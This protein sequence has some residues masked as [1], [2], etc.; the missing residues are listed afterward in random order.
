MEVDPDLK[1]RLYSVLASEGSTL[2]DWFVARAESFITEQSQPLLF[3]ETVME[4]AQPHTV[5]SEQ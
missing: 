4:K 1:R 3:Q 2:K 5:E